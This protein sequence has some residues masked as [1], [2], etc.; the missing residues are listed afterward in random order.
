MGTN[1]ELPKTIYHYTTQEGLLGILKEEELWATKVQYLNDASEL[2]EP[3]KIA[4]EILNEKLSHIPPEKM[5]EPEGVVLGKWCHDTSSWRAINCFTASFCE[6]KDL[7]SQWRGYG[8]PR[9]PCSIGFDSKKLR[10][11]TCGLNIEL[12]PCD[13]FNRTGY[14][15]K[16]TEFVDNSL[17]EVTTSPGI[18]RSFIEK[19]VKLSLTMKLD[20]FRDEREW[21][22]VSSTP[23][24]SARL[25]FRI[26]NSLIIPYFPL[27][28][29]DLSSIVEL[30]IGPCPDPELAKD[31]IYTL[32]YRYDLKSVLK[33]K[34]SNSQIP[35]RVF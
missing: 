26:R 20:C 33:G 16:I 27:P 5:W 14:R 22:I 21:R 29:G 10:E 30:C 18:Q 8:L 28:L 24:N 19:L 15:R 6:G 9:S 35:Y 4:S 7:L 34:V 23:L 1:R 2:T 12:K 31:A 13:Y 11:V 25:E 3:L 17:H 32:A